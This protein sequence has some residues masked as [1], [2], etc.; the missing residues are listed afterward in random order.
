VNCRKVNN[1]LSAYM[2]GELPGVEQLQIRQHLRQCEICHEEHETLLLTKRMLSG[3]KMKEPCT[4]LEARILERLAKEGSM[5]SASD[6]SSHPSRLPS[7]FAFQS[8]WGVLAY[9]QKLRLSGMLAAGSV[10]IALLVIVPTAMRKPADQEPY[11]TVTG[12]IPVAKQSPMA[13]NLIPN[14]PTDSFYRFPEDTLVKYHNPVENVNVPHSAGSYFIEPVSA[15]EY[16][17]QKR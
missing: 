11:E 16:P 15:N 1:L 7:L 12:M 4:N 3:L 13:P 9:P 10:T 6:E 2:D 5:T 14:A 17:A 8:W